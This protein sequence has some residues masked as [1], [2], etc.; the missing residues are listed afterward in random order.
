MCPC[1]ARVML[2]GSLVGMQQTGLCLE[3][4]NVPLGDA[5][6]A[7]GDSGSR[8][9]TIWKGRQLADRTDR[10]WQRKKGI[11]KNQKKMVASRPLPA[12]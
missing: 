2:T 4:R 11:P 5:D 8:S 1:K 12:V 10:S 7:H 9:T 3:M 6:D